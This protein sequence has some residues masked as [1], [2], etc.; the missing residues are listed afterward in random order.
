MNAMHAR[1]YRQLRRDH[2]LASARDLL[3]WAKAP[4]AS[5]GWQSTRH[6]G[7]WTREVEG[8]QICLRV[9]DESI[10]PHEDEYGHYVAEVR[11]DNYEWC[12][13][14]PEP[15]E[16]LP[17]GLPYTAFRYDGYDRGDDG[18]YFVPVGVED[19]YDYYRGLGQSKSVARQLTR[20]WIEST[21]SSYFSSPLI[22]AEIIIEA[23]KAGVL[24]GVASIGTSYTGD[25]DG[26]AYVFECAADH[27]LITDAI[28]YAERMLEQLRS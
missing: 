22:N 15:A 20:D 10:Y 5:E 28:A 12:G 6:D 7:R 4:D 24:L 25:D 16:A 11:G 8:Y 21:I 13:N 27:E 19:Q 2:P 17:L 18:G 3:R 14:Y 23:C 9:E 1:K 26:R